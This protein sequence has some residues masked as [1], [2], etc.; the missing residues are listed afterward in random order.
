[1]ENAYII[2]TPA[3]SGARLGKSTGP[4]TEKDMDMRNVP[5]KQAIECSSFVA[6]TIRPD[7]A[8]A[9]NAVS[10]FSL[11]PGKPLWEAVKRIFRILK[12]TVTKKLKYSRNPTDKLKGYS[13]ADWGG[14]PDS[15]R[16]TS[17]YVFTLQGVAI[18]ENV[19]KQPPVAL[20]SR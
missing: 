16:S 19:K 13:D 14:D 2:A 15:R 11:N 12:E 20:S 10:Q 6:Q 8:F 18:S 17:E 4:K 5:H 9:V 7:I 1:M 3:D